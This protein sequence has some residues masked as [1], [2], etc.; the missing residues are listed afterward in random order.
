VLR[1]VVD[2]DGKAAFEGVGRDLADVVGADTFAVSARQVEEMLAWRKAGAWDR[3]VLAVGGITTPE[4]A[5]HLLHEGADAALV[6]TAAL[7]DPLFATRFRKVATTTPPEGAAPGAT[8]GASRVAKRSAPG[9]PSKSRR[10]KHAV[11]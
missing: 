6:A 5:M 10:S 11:R 8:N 4:R 1:R 3:V 2:E 7:V 9:R